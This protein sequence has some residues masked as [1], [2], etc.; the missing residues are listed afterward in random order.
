[1]IERT[2]YHGQIRMELTR[3][4]SVLA[5]LR[6]SIEHEETPRQELGRELVK[7]LSQREADFEELLDELTRADERSW[8]SLRLDLELA[9]TRLLNHLDR[10]LRFVLLPQSHAGDWREPFNEGFDEGAQAHF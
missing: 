6:S 8:A 2:R 3:I 5:Q 10:A 1:M 9:R 7:Q 4:D